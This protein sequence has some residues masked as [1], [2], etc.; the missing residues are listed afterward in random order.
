[1]TRKDL[2]R[3]H[4]TRQ[5]STTRNTPTRQTA[6]NK[7]LYFI[8]DENK[9]RQTRATIENSDETNY[10]DKDIKDEFLQDDGNKAG[11]FVYLDTIG[12]FKYRNC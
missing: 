12:N 8:I 1:M 9:D 11:S 7:V 6:N 10:V 2:Q 5:R 3:N 4:K